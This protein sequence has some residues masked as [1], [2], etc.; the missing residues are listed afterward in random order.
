M[1]L[2]GS[3]KHSLSAPAAQT[4]DQEDDGGMASDVGGYL[5]S[6]GHVDSGHMS[7]RR[8]FD[9]G[10]RK[11]VSKVALRSK[12]AKLSLVGTSAGDPTTV[13]VSPMRLEPW[14]QIPDPP[15]ERHEYIKKLLGESS[16]ENRLS[17][18]L[19]GDSIGD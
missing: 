2:F 13:A 14:G 8:S 3:H 10:D 6:N 12:F 5:S 4:S 15:K 9:E 11:K 1:T 17:R 16:S 7:E 18:L 19:G